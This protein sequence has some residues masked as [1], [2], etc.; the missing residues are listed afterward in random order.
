MEPRSTTALFALAAPHQEEIW[1]AAFASQGVTAVRAMEAPL[2]QLL[3]TTPRVAEAFDVALVDLAVLVAEATPLARLVRRA[4]LHRPDMRLIAVHTARHTVEPGELR[5]AR[6]QGAGDLLPAVS[7]ARMRVEGEDLLARAL[8]S[9]VPNARRLRTFLRAVA[10]GP[11]YG[12][13]DD[14]YVVIERLASRGVDLDELARRMRGAQ[15]VAVRDRSYRF[16]S[17]A[18]CFVGSE[19]VDW[20]ARTAKLDRTLALQA[21]QALCARGLFH[22]VVKEHS[23]RDGAFFYRFRA[24]TEAIDA[25]DIDELVKLMRGASGVGIRTRSYL[26]KSYPECFVGSEAVDWMARTYQLDREQAVALGQ[27]LID[28]CLLHHVV[29][30]HDFVD[31]AF[32]YR[33]FSDE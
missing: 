23:L 22:H 20:I 10:H 21:G 3:G 12:V 5:W 25:I 9:A 17:Y 27:R 33:F 11:G 28:L 19:A 16:K 26:G 7:V 13:D 24:P 14:P 2:L 32:F 6:S 4:R 15:G 1:R 18:A 30:E 29:D 8:G 31:G